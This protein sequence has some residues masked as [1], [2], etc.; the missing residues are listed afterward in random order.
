MVDAQSS[1]LVSMVMLS[2]LVVH[3]ANAYQ[4]SYLVVHG[5]NAQSSYLVSPW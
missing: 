4:S 5:S 3:V 1:Y 2:S